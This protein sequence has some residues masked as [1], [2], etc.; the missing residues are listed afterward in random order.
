VT[1]CV[2]PT[3]ARSDTLTSAP[4]SDQA[5]VWYAGYG[6][7]IDEGRFTFYL[8]GGRPPGAVREAPG[9]RDPAPPRDQ[10]GVVLP[11][12]MFF[13]WESPTWGGGISF[14][15]AEADGSAFARAYLVTR[16]Q[17]ADIAAQEMHRTPGDDLDLTRVLENQSHTFGPGRYETVHLVGELDHIPMLTFTSSAGAQVPPNAPSGAYLATVVRGLRATHALPNGEIADYL[18]GCDGMETWAPD[19]VRRLVAATRP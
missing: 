9:A 1:T 3:A 2:A 16:E 11:G 4:G 12:R 17:F 15:D 8:T 19:E 6:S 14:L 7:N 13:G 5:L 18:L 10:R